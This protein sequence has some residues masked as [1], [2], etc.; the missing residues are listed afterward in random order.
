MQNNDEFDL[1]ISAA[2]ATYADPGPESG[3]ARRVLDRI[4]MEPAP[5]LRRRWLP[6]AVALP[7]AACLLLLIFVHPRPRIIQSQ[8]KQANQAAQLHDPEI[9]IARTKAHAA[10][11]REMAQ[12]A[13]AAG[14]NHASAALA[15]ASEPLPKLDVFPTSEPLSSRERALVVLVA[16]TP[17][18]ELR[19]LAQSQRQE[20]PLTV[21]SIHV[22]TLEPSD[23]GEN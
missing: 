8:S 17:Q 21:A 14:H 19:A 22:L 6:W 9:S 16:R 3:L 11:R 10:V 20:I 15:V 7:A 18:P 23:E 2:L 4:A 12:R 13:K 5:A 1:S